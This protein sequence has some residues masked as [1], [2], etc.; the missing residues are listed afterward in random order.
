MKRALL[1]LGAACS[2][3][4]AAPE[5]FPL[6][7]DGTY[8]RDLQ[9]RIALLRGVNARAQGAF[10][11]TFNDGRTALEPIPEITQNDCLRMRQLG[12][13][14]L[15]LPINWSALEPE[16]DA[17]DE[18]YLERVDAIVQNAGI[19][20]LF[21]LID[22]HQDAY[23]KEIGEDG[24]P[25][26]AIQPPPQMLLQGP[27][28]DLEARRTSP[29]VTA[30]FDTFFDQTDA[31]GLQQAFF[32]ALDRVV[33]RWAEDPSVIG[34]EIFNEPPVGEDLVDAFHFAAAAHVH[35]KAPTKLV[36]FEPSAVR[37]LFDFVPKATAPF[38]VANAVYAPHVYTFV[39]Y[40]D[41]TQLQN[42]TPDA[43]E[44][45][46]EAARAEAAAW[47]TPLLIGE[48]GIG[49]TAPNADLWMGVEAELHDR[50]LAGDAFWL[51]KEASQ[52]SWGV[53][54]LSGSTWSERPQV[55]NW[56]SRIH[57]SRIAGDVVANTYNHTTGALELEVK[58]GTTHGLEHT[59]YIPERA[60]STYSVTCDG[61]ALGTTRN[62]DTGL[63]APSCDGVLDVAP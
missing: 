17:L 47:K 16:Q 29:Q 28:T 56:I 59:I 37:N 33:E 36:M 20:G 49:P 34:F 38:P 48:Y 51:W 12:F 26:W 19:A 41:P 62:A 50:F 13:N 23:S 52:G 1:L 8:L 55:V 61:T 11:V 60:A 30:A 31:T 2:K 42:L 4:A 5:A 35:A 58:R 6:H 22:F 18:S 54:D 3:P 25:L 53:F 21:V 10:D 14:L 44:P 40:S 24:A 9:G 57:A 27:L 7:S 15:R 39:F 46:V 45:S 63:I 32:V 43:L